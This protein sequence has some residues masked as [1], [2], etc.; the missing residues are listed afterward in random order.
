MLANVNTFALFGLESFAVR[1]EVDISRGLPAFNIVGLPDA[2]VKEAGDRVRAAV[3]NSGFE[4]PVKKITV[5]LSPAYLKKEGPHFDL[6]I[7]LG[8]LVASGQLKGAA[9]AGKGFIGELSLSGSLG[10]VNGVL[11]MAIKAGD[12]GCE[13]IFLP[14]DNAAE[15]ALAGNIDV[16]P[17]ATLQEIIKITLAE[18]TVPYRNTDGSEA[19]SPDSIDF[20]WIKGQESIKRALLVAAAGGH[21][22]LMAGPPGSGKTMLARSLPSILPEMSPEECLEVTKIYSV[23]GL[24]KTRKTLIKTRPFRSPHHS[25]TGPALIGGGRL[26]RCGEISLAHNGVLFLDEATEFNRYVLEV[27]RQPLE[28]GC[29]TIGRARG[30]VT[31]PAA[32][33]LV[34]AMNPCPCGYYGYSRCSCT[35]GQIQRYRSKISGPLLDRIDI[36]MEVPPVSYEEL[37]ETA[38]GQTSAA[39]RR[40]VAKARETQRRRLKTQGKFCNAQIPVALIKKYCQLSREAERILAE[41]YKGMKLSARS[42]HRILRLSRTIADLDGKAH[43]EAHHLLEALQ[44]RLEKIKTLS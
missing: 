12:I 19:P 21:N 38:G 31:F 18:N 29:V 5:N 27:L 10:H 4:Y 30:S 44:Y 24:L 36:F 3:R 23:A 20:S 25:I 35:D 33:S 43:I 1:V 17:A 13:G 16:F 14:K 22:I 42:F 15:A 7:A 34:M 11:P 37:S 9:L 28:E 39:L 32:F 8:I 6:P 2:A 26:P 41:S 40:I